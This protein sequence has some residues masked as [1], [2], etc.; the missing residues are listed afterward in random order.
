LPCA[1]VEY[2]DLPVILTIDQA[3]AAGMSLDQPYVQVLPSFRRALYFLYRSRRC[4]RETAYTRA[5]KEITY[6]R[7]NACTTCSWKGAGWRAWGKAQ[8]KVTSVVIW[9]PQFS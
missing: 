9:A 4:E 8:T 6:F 5:E 7:L 2:E 3:I 1:Q